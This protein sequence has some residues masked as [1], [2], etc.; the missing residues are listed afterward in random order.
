MNTSRN[1]KTAP[2][3]IRGDLVSVVSDSGRSVECRIVD[4][5]AH[6]NRLWVRLPTDQTLELRWQDRRRAWVGHMARM[7][8][9]VQGP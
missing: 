1:F 2:R 7:E 8:F 5:E 6:S 9:L 3:W 4:W